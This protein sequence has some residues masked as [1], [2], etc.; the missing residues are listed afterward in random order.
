LAPSPIEKCTPKFVTIVLSVKA[1]PLS[2]FITGFLHIWLWCT[3][4]AVTFLSVC[5]LFFLY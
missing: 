4:I 3:R 5:Y 2:R 1:V